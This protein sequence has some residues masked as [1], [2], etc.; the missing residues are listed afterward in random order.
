MKKNNIE[1]SKDKDELRKILKK[2]DLEENMRLRLAEERND[3]DQVI[4]NISP[5]IFEQLQK[6]YFDMKETGYGGSYADFLRSKIRVTKANGGL[7]SNYKIES[8][9]P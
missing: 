2:G 7:I 9:K 3:S 1:T 8:R 5:D 6:E 4:I